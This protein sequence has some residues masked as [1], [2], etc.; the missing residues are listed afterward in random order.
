MRTTLLCF[1]L[2]LATVGMGQ[3]G[4]D[5]NNAIFSDPLLTYDQSQ[6]NG[7]FAVMALSQE[8]FDYYVT[9]ITKFSGRFEKIYFLN[10]TYGDNRIVNIDADIEKPQL[11]FKAHYQYSQNEMTCLLDDF[12]KETNKISLSW[13]ESDKAAWLQ[14][15]DKFN[16]PNSN[17]K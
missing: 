1:L 11:W 17:E 9:D 2:F 3:A 10:L 15:F 6:F 13:T 14:K 7:R 4:S 12:M 16:I 8:D 5:G